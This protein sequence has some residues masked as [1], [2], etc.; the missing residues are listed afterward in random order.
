VAK[1]KLWGSLR[2]AVGKE[3][4]SVPDGISLRKMIDHL[5]EKYGGKVKEQIVNRKTTKPY[6]LILVNG[7]TGKSLDTLIKK[8][9]KIEIFPPV[10]G[11]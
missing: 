5:A 1:V 8:G 7:D 11:G 4:V 10:G 3:S 9:D 6:V 2:E